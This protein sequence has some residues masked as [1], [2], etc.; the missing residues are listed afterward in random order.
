MKILRIRKKGYGLKHIFERRSIEGFSDDEV[1]F[2]IVTALKAAEQESYAEKNGNKLLFDKFGVRAVVAINKDNKKI[3]TGFVLVNREGEIHAALPHENFY[4]LN[5]LGRVHL[6]GASLE[7]ALQ[8]F[9][10]IVNKN[11]K[12]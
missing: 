6:M 8:K 9:D 4:A 7:K 3:I 12:N 2:V 5:E 11:P 1:A 10:R